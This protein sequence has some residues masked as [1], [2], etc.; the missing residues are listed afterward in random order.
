MS[1]KGGVRKNFVAASPYP[2]ADLISPWEKFA[3]KY[4]GLLSQNTPNS[5]I[6]FDDWTIFFPDKDTT[7]FIPNV[8]GVT[9]QF[10]SSPKFRLWLN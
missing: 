5:C 1:I 9:S 3:Q 2:A 7:K 8:T 10:D 4:R 6:A